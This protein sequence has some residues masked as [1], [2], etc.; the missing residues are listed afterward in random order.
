LTAAPRGDL[1]GA[2]GA[3]LRRPSGRLAGLAGGAMRWVNRQPYS[4]AI[5]ALDVRPGDQVL[6]LGF[7]PGEGVRALS[8]LAPDGVVWG[9]DHSAAMVAQAGKRNARA[10]ERGRVVL[11]RAGF[12][13]LPLPHASVD[14]VLAVNVAYFWGEGDAVL[15]EIGRVLRPGGRLSVFVTDA[16]AMGRWKFAGPDTHTAFT[17]ESLARCLARGP[18]AADG[19]QVDAVT[20]PFGLPGLV[21]TA[22][23]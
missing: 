10:I 19:I 15:R 16:A 17:A 22:R 13:A 18:F 20:L 5:A 12:E 8:A 9:V 14:R 3:Q 4:L 1:W 2:V 7:G 21:A 23:R 11:R 6:E